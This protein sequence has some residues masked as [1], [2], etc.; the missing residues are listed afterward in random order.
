MSR[1]KCTDLQVDKAGYK[2]LRRELDLEIAYRALMAGNIHEV[3]N[4]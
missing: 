3:D 1:K 4:T 2:R